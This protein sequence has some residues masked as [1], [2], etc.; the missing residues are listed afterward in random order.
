MDV[1]PRYESGSLEFDEDA[2]V[3]SKVEKLYLADKAI[4]PLSAEEENELLKDKK[5]GEYPTPEALDILIRS[6]IPIIVATCNKRFNLAKGPL[7]RDAINVGIMAMIEASKDYV[8]GLGCKF[9]SY[10]MVR[11]RFQIMEFIIRNKTTESRGG[12]FIKTTFKVLRWIRENKRLL[13]WTI[14]PEVAR[15]TG[16]TEKQVGS[17]LPYLRGTRYIEDDYDD[18]DE[19]TAVVL[20]HRG[21]QDFFTQQSSD[22]VVEYIEVDEEK[23]RL[24]EIVKSLLTEKEYFIYVRLFGFEGHNIYTLEEIGEMFVPATT[25]QNVSLH[26]LKAIRKLRKNPVVK[27]IDREVVYN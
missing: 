12:G 9:V 6:N 23:L 7:M 20:E 27:N 2:S 1:N 22:P 26:Y 19:G 4:P 5:I 25:K 18:D 24:M 8:T 14:I 15:D 3:R 10:T 17:V 11:V 16:L 13:E 21:D